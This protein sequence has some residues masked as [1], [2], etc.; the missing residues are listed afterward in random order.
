MLALR[1]PALPM[2]ALR[3][4]GI[5]VVALSAS[6][7]DRSDQISNQSA[8]A[9]QD[10]PSTAAVDSPATAIASSIA[11]PDRYAGDR[12]QDVWRKSQEI[13]EFMQVK[14]GMQVIDYFAGSG[15]FS[16]LLS[17][18]VGPSGSVV[19]YN[20]HGYAE[21]GG[22]H[23]VK[24]FADARLANAKVITEETAAFK[25]PA[26]SVDAVLLYM[27]YHDLY[28]VQEKRTEPMGIPS[29]VNAALFAAV[30]PG[31]VVVVID[32]SAQPGGDTAKV[33][34]ALHRIDP[35][36]VKNDFVAAGFLFDA[37]SEL[38]RH[39]EDDRTKVVFDE[40]LRHRTDRFIYRFRKPA[41]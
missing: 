39:P 38:M 19:V 17:R 18:A 3:M 41:R 28:W 11:N 10:S 35:Q 36:T 27:S 32:H 16:E 20:N 9:A 24:R 37:E 34:G 14:P 8:S 5:A 21:F 7:C 29:Q 2:A 33:V 12:E 26:D 30:K 4:L 6:G 15:Y 25:L 1:M 22:E 31:G 40:S 13:L 23:L